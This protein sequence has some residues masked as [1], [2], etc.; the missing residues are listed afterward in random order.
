MFVVTTGA[1]NESC[2]GN[3][4][5]GVTDLFIATPLVDAAGAVDF[6][7]AFV[8]AMPPLSPSLFVVIL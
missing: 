7:T 6:T 2:E 1:G 8:V 5:G 4:G 3:N